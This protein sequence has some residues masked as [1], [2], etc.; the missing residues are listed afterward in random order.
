M[1]FLKSSLFFWITT[2]C[3]LIVLYW[4]LGFHQ[5]LQYPPIS[6]HQSAQASR[7]SVALNYAQEGMNFFKP[8]VHGCRNTSGI[9]G[10]EFPIINYG[11]AIC[12][13]V[14]GFHDFWFRFLMLITITLG[15]VYAI[16]TARLFT[17]HAWIAMSIAV[18]WFLS[19]IL[20]YYSPN[21][22]PDT[23]S[24]G[25]VMISWFYAF[26][27]IHTKKL[28]AL[29]L[30][31]LFLSLA[32]LT[33][34]VS[35][36]SV[37]VVFAL[38]VLHSIR[39]ISLQLTRKQ[40]LA[41]IVCGITV[42]VVTLIWYKYARY[43]TESSGNRQFSLRLHSP[44]SID[45]FREVW[46]SISWQ[47]IPFY[48]S[49]TM[50]WFLLGISVIS[51]I[52]YKQV[53]RLL[54]TITLLLYLGAI[55]FFIL[56]LPQFKDHDYYIITLLPAV[57]F[58]ML[59]F[60][61]TVQK[62]RFRFTWHIVL[63]LLL[64][65]GIYSSIHARKHQESRYGGVYYIWD[66]DF[67]PYYNLEPK[68]RA[69][70]I[71]PND[72]FVSYND[73]T[74]NNSLY[75]INQKGWTISQANAYKMPIALQDCKYALINDT[76]I[77]DNPKFSRFFNNPIAVFPK[78]L[79]LFKISHSDTAFQRDY[80]YKTID[81]LS[82]PYISY[83]SNSFEE[84]F[85]P[86]NTTTR[87]SRTGKNSRVITSKTGNYICAK[88]PNDYH[89]VRVQAYV[90]GDCDQLIMACT[91]K[92]TRYYSEVTTPANSPKNEWNK[93][94]LTYT[95]RYLHDIDTISFFIKNKSNSEAYVDDIF[96]ELRK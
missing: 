90:Y 14:F 74:P 27:Y 38:I 95:K 72:K 23:A 8:Q 5:A 22:N 26:S 39:F 24:L 35:L 43:L 89:T 79:T 1:K 83:I 21:Y 81:R 37:V 6:I 64:S 58:H 54:F 84:D 47:W 77:I 75:L 80:V 29:F 51:A 10:L 2:C 88:I 52:L 28:S 9:T 55:A 78:N 30:W 50:Y 73:W 56:M 49:Y 87:I 86:G 20:V 91:H 53:S 41:W 62:I 17:R 13:K 46:K 70:G 85:V 68:L 16:R 67:S 36:I 33:K 82:A 96:I 59:M 34:L 65:L 48:Y 94:E 69:L 44:K 25:F 31:T 63:V 66:N 18:V 57:F 3:L 93:I 61:T 15:I 42:I 12:Y 4:F 71:S 32:S 11:A 60:V 7:A 40:M 92:Q 76:A 19:P 45:T